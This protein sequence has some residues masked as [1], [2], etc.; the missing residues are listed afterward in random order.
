V[1]AGWID[2]EYRY[3]LVSFTVHHTDKNTNGLCSSVYSRGAGNYSPPSGTVDYTSHWW[4]YWRFVFVGVF[5]KRKALFPFSF[6]WWQLKS[7]KWVAGS[8]GNYWWTVNSNA[9]V[10]N[11]FMIVCTIY[12]FTDRITDGPWKI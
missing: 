4:T 11:A 5:Q 12:S 6:R 2:R 8:Q 1:F 9:L 7:T 10:I 3:N